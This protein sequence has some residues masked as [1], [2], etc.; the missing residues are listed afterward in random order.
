M[1]RLHEK[2]DVAVERTVLQR[3]AA[4]R[5][6]LCWR[7]SRSVVKLNVPRKRSSAQECPYSIWSKHLMTNMAVML[8][9]PAC[10]PMAVHLF[11]DILREVVLP[12][13]V[14]RSAPAQWQSRHS[15][16]SIVESHTSPCS[17]VV[18][19]PRCDGLA[20][21]WMSEVGSAQHVTV[22]CRQSFR[23]TT[24]ADSTHRSG[25]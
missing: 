16:V 6:M 2:V 1:D 17:V 10:M 14:D 5:V 24:Y 15:L 20:W 11:V 9:V 22:A 7:P 13:L 19:G 3:G 4:C 21:E 25:Q 23:K 12:S 18:R 8:Y